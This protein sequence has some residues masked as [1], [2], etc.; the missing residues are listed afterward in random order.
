MLDQTRKP[1]IPW[2]RAKTITIPIPKTG[3]KFRQ[4]PE[5]PARP[6]EVTASFDFLPIDGG[7]AWHWRIKLD[8]PLFTP[9]TQTPAA[10]AAPYRPAV[11]SDKA[12]E[13]AIAEILRLLRDEVDIRRHHKQ[14]NV[15]GACAQAVWH[16]EQFAKYFRETGKFRHEPIIPGKTKPREEF[17]AEVEAVAKVGGKIPMSFKQIGRE[18]GETMEAKLRR[19]RDLHIAGD[20]VLTIP[21]INLVNSFLRLPKRSTT[22]RPRG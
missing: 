4:F 5:M 12:I 14:T 11:S 22:T 2:K 1:S 20:V 13:A 19:L 9:I 7:Q 10:R 17:E 21:D 3:T 8:T 15:A 6:C 18:M 16:V